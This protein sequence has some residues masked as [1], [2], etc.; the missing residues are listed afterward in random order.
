MAPAAIRRLSRNSPAARFPS[1]AP[2]EP[3]CRRAVPSG[4]YIGDD[5][6]REEYRHAATALYACS[7]V[8]TRGQITPYTPISST[9]FA[10]HWFIS[11]PLAGMRTI[12]VTA[13]ESRGRGSGGDS[14]ALADN[15]GA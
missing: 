6:G 12:G 9:C 13:G 10:S 15:H 7:T 8:L 5:F 3:D 2:H 4:S 11:P 14:A 1:S